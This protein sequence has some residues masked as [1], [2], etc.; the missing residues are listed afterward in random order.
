MLKVNLLFK[1]AAIVLFYIISGFILLNSGFVIK[2]SFAEISS[3]KITKS[4]DRKEASKENKLSKKEFEKLIDSSLMFNEKSLNYLKK[5][6]YAYRNSIPIGDLLP[7][8]FPPEIKEDVSL[9]SSSGGKGNQGRK[10]RDSKF[11]SKSIESIGDKFSNLQNKT[12]DIISKPSFYLNSVVYFEPDNW[13]IWL[14]NEAIKP[15]DKHEI[16]DIHEVGKNYVV[17]VWKNANISRIYPDWHKKF[18]STGNNYA[19]DNKNMVLNINSNDLYFILH[20]NQSLVTKEMVVKEGDFASGDKKINNMSNNIYG[21]APG[22]NINDISRNK[23]GY[24]TPDMALASEGFNLNKVKSGA[25]KSKKSTNEK[26]SSS[27]PLTEAM[28]L[29]EQI[30]NT[31]H[32]YAPDTKQ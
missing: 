26:N 28:R 32:M 2:D 11:L 18:K 27:D 5:A 23:K 31:L 10:S 12:E 14:N 20:P 15:D 7:D 17:F 25:G 6:H 29:S 30:K 4:G 8:L 22:L 3:K 1:E 24:N 19:S 21:L 9:N 13:V 16:L